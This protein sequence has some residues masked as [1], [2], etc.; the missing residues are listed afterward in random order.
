MSDY[1]TGM[2]YDRTQ[3]DV[4]ARDAKGFWNAS[5]LNRVEAKMKEV[6]D[7]LG[8]S[9]NYKT[10][11]VGDLVY[12]S[13]VNSILSDISKLRIAWRVASD[14]PSVPSPNGFDYR[15]ANAIERILSD[16]DDFVISAR[17]DFLYSDQAFSGQEV[18]L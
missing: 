3:A 16:L 14:C 4:D 5:D 17:T 13:D 12:L 7:Y 2:V 9:V 8:L 1:L 15:S 11:A 18:I 10:W 6:A